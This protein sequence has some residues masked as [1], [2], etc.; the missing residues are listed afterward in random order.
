M[1]KVASFLIKHFWG[2]AAGMADA[3]GVLLLTWNQAFY[4]Y[5]GFYFDRLERCVRNNLK[6]LSLLRQRNILSMTEEDEPSIA[7]LFEQFLDALAISEKKKRGVKSPVGAAKALHL[8]APEFLPL[9]DDKIARAYRCYYGSDPTG[10][11]VS[12]C[13]VSRL[14]AAELEVFARQYGKPI[15]K[16]ID[17]YNYARFTKR[18]V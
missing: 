18:L 6:L 7:R 1:Y 5:G 11:Y 17:E 2:D 3:L 4:R 16:L 14:M 15:L 12:F 8:L 10:S 13:R 9:W